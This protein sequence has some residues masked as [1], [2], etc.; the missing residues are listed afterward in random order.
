[1][2]KLMTICCVVLVFAFA[3]SIVKAE[4]LET[5]NVDSKSASPIVSTTILE[6]GK[7][8]VIEVT[9]R[10]GYDTQ[11]SIADAEW[12]Y[13]INRATWV[14][15]YGI[16][17]GQDVLD[18]IIN[19][20]S[21]DWMGTTDEIVTCDSVFAPHVRSLS[22]T[23]RLCFTGEGTPLSL[24]VYDGDGP[25]PRYSDNDGI[26]EVKIIYEPDCEPGTVIDHQKI[27][28]TEGNFTGTLHDDDR[29]SQAI[30]SLGDLDGDGI[31]DIVVGAP[32]DDDGGT[33]RGAVWVL[34]LKPDGTVK[35]YQKIS[36]ID[37]NFTGTLDD[38]DAFGLSVTCLGDLDGDG[39]PDIAVGAGGDD[40]G[41]NR[42]GAVWI[43]FLNTDG[44]VKSHQKISDTEGNFTGTLYDDDEISHA[45]A[46]L[47]DLD[48]DEVCDI[49][50]GA[51]GDDD[52][53]P[54][55]GA[56]WILFLNADGTVNS[57]Q[58][59]S[60]TEG[61]FTG[62]L[63]DDRFG[64]SIAAL[65]D[66]DNDGIN[67]IAVGAHVDDD[68]GF[69]KGAVWI[70][71]LNTDG[72]VKSHQKIS[73]TQGN[74]NGSLDNGD[75]FGVSVTTMGDL[76]GDGVTEV[77]VGAYA[78]DD[79][80]YD[81]GAV[82]TLFLNTDGTVKSHQKISDTE[83]NFTGSLDNVDYF[84]MSVAS[85][86]DLNGDQVTDVAIG[87][88]FD[89]DGGT[90]RGAVWIFFLCGVPEP[91]SPIDALIDI[92]PDTLNKKS[93]GR[94]VT[95]YITLPDGYD[96]GAI[97]TSSVAISSLVGES[98]VPEYSQQADLSFVP[99]VGDRDEDGIADLTIKFDRQVLLPNLC[100]DDVA[101]TIEG[102]LT[103]GEHFSGSDTIRIIDRGK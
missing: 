83:G 80:G 3:N 73:N 68:G 77:I 92:D 48:G 75:L 39:K 46:S 16:L 24:Q 2:K 65:G 86:G 81:I 49:A 71:F 76:D 55:R 79:G 22:H 25:G 59:I 20:T 17:N 99:Q 53:G 87:G 23:Y 63:D 4:L 102:E 11:G 47:G 67:D 101:V 36:D 91:C 34:F 40:D 60:D 50:V 35:D 41:G 66:L 31:D 8:Y 13:D 12:S 78:D 32:N 64:V 72:T 98:C 88:V 45:V 95:V 70:L 42:R 90:D 56:V 84:G 97:D 29:L 51:Y 57:H 1:M 15:L 62:I 33:N 74:F 21:Y 52:G 100:L 89:D 38:N 58:K 82:W 44:T 37:G 96:V 69:N 18:L 27:S 10:Y 85:I 93:H 26:L 7:Q 19:G 61:N 103:T 14:E 28:D 94:W 54:N 43:L 9:G 6:L 30:A 5:V